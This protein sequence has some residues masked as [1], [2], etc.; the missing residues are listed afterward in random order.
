MET[1]EIYK[2]HKINITQSDFIENPFENWDGLPCIVVESRNS[3]YEG[4]KD[5][6]LN[7]LVKYLTD[8]QVIYH[9][10]KLLELGGESVEN[11]N[12]EY[13][14]KDYSKGE[15]VE[16]LRYLLSTFL[17][18][19]ISNMVKFCEIFKIDHYSETSKGYSQ[20]DWYDVLLIDIDQD[21]DYPNGVDTYFESAFD[22]F[23]AWCWGDVYQ[24]RIDGLTSD[25]YGVFYGSDHM[26]SGLLESAKEAINSELDSDISELFEKYDSDTETLV[27]KLEGLGYESDVKNDIVINFE[28]IT[29]M[30][31][32]KFRLPVF[33]GFDNSVLVLEYENLLLEDSS[34][35]FRD[36]CKTVSLKFVKYLE[37]VIN[38]TLELSISLTNLEIIHAKSGYYS[39]VLLTDLFIKKK[40][41]SLIYEYIQDYKEVFSEYLAE[42][43]SDRVGYV[44]HID[45]DYNTFMLAML[46]TSN[47]D[48]IKYLHVALEFLLTE[49]HEIDVDEI[50]NELIN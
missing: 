33:D 16:S 31:F 20:S 34:I 21:V 32:E 45:T 10:K 17:A 22:L 4:N 46:S 41:I 28:K 15:R 37:T 47:P 40:D 27:K 18:D 30:K 36:F 24:Y 11:F 29:Y 50:Y 7:Y 5:S 1:L 6:V 38:N 35:E 14:L 23:T 49:I 8:N 44:S 13:P 19:S 9:Q 39:D 43:H 26:E 42:N 12:I 25:C 2:G 48:C 3:N